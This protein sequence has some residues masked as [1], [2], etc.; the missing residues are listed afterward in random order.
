MA[1]PG[2]IRGEAVAFLLGA[3]ETE[4]LQTMAAAHVPVVVGR[5]FLHSFLLC[6]EPFRD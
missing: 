6:L 2:V 3:W 5:P 4:E 1:G